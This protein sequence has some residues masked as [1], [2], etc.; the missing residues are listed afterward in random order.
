MG[1]CWSCSWWWHHPALPGSAGSCSSTAVTQ[2]EWKNSQQ[3]VLII[4]L[5]TQLN[6]QCFGSRA[7]GITELLLLAGAW[8]G[9]WDL[10]GLEDVDPWKEVHGAVSCVTGAL[11]G[12]FSCQFVNTGVRQSRT[13][14]IMRHN[15]FVVWTDC[16]KNCWRSIENSLCPKGKIK[17]V[18]P[19]MTKLEPTH[20]GLKDTYSQELGSWVWVLI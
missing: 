1:Q 17:D 14:W 4:C 2:L 15:L 20:V 13:F 10:A 11:M 12:S 16:Q 7:E 19:N 8:G 9:S 6:E 5:M 3:R 18:F